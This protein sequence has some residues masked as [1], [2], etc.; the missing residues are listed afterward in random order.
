MSDTEKK[1][2]LTIDDQ[3]YVRSSIKNFL[4]DYD[5][6]VIEAEN[7][8]IGLETFEH[9]KPDLL[10]VDLRMPELDGLDVLK[11]V[12]EESPET[13]V[14][15]VSGTGVLRDAV[16]ALRLG[17]WDYILKPIEDMEVLL[18]VVS[19][20]LEKARLSR[21]NICYRQN[22]E[23]MVEQRTR[24]LDKTNRELLAEIDERK[25]VEQQREELLKILASKR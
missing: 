11:K 8:R 20:S 7:G 24:E 22:M 14:V 15:I 13:P 5:Y 16:V 25:R 3:E 4:E 6:S 10:L 18:H 2:I 9:E 23:R 21:E 12:R 19:K 17:A 1:V